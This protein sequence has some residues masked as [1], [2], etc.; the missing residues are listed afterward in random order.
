MSEWSPLLILCFPVFSVII[1]MFP[2]EIAEILSAI[3]S[4]IRK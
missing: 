2:K 3:A 1:L 4:R